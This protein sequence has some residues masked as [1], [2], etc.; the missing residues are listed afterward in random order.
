MLGRFANW[1]PILLLW[2][3]GSWWW[4][5][6]FGREQG[7]PIPFATGGG[8]DNCFLDGVDAGVCVPL[9]LPSLSPQV[10]CFPSFVIVGA[11][12]A[13]TGVLMHLLN[14]HPLLVSGKG[15]GG[16]NEIHFFRSARHARPG[17]GLIR[18]REAANVCAGD[19]RW[20]YLTHF[21]SF[22][23]EGK[24]MQPQLRV[25]TF[26]KSPDYMRSKSS[27]SRLHAMLPSAKLIV[28]LRNPAT[29][30]LSEFN[31][32]CRH[33]RYLHPPR[34]EGDANGS[35]TV[36]YQADLTGSSSAGLRL[37]YPCSLDDFRQY[38]FSDS[39]TPTLS[40]HARREASHGFYAQ[41]LQWILGEFD[42]RQILLLFQ[43]EMQTATLQTCAQVERFV[44]VHPFR[45]RIAASTRAPPWLE[46]QA[47]YRQTRTDLET[48]Y[49]AHNQQLLRILA[50][51]F[52]RTK[53][54][55]EWR[56]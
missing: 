21:P 32:N 22:S 45:Y 38:Y 43:E 56:A 28:L 34:R 39:S 46:S 13:G 49:R 50:T 19:E 54:P 10:R 16:S 55:A 20:A 35:S 12:K 40:N 14:Q 1:A 37:R 33:G 15:E 30:A 47:L 8:G 2:G 36:V 52:N 5:L 23:A 51:H 44:D 17:G 4:W 25:K 7:V 31:H 27:I 11:M 41:Q 48:I 6:R 24:V 3:W 42:S 29:R 53:L 18:G 9:R 26:D